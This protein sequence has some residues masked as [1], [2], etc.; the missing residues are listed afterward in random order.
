MTNQIINVSNATELKTAL[1]AATG[2]E[3]VILAAGDYGKLSISGTQF[4]SNVTLKSADA[5]GMASFSEAYLKNSS[6]ITFD[7]I[8]FD[9]SYS[10]GEA[11]YASKF[12]V[13][14]STNISFNDSLF[15][16]DAANGTGT[17]ADGLGTGK[18][19]VVKGSTN[20]DVV[21][22]EFHS[23]W[24]GLS[25]NTS[26]NI[27][28][29]GNNIHN[30]RSDGMKLG[31][32]QTVLVEKNYIHDFNGD[33]T[34][35][36]HRDM[37]QIQRS[38]GT[39]V[40]D[41]TIRDNVFDMGSGD[42]TQTIWAGRDKGNANDPT[43]WHQNVLIENNV[44]YNAHTHGISL[45]LTDGLTIRDNSLIAVDR[46][47]T[48]GISIPKILVSSE[49]KS[50]V[51]ENNITPAIGGEQGQAD[52]S[53]QNNAFIQNT[54][55]NAPGYY[56]NQFIYHATALA[57]GHNQF[58]IAVGSM[59]DQLT[60]GSSLSNQPSFSY[61]DW[62]GTASTVVSNP[63]SSGGVGNGGVV[64]T[65][66]SNTDTGTEGSVTE[67]DSASGPS[68]AE[69]PEMP[70][71]GG[72]T[73]GDTNVPE[74]NENEAGDAEAPEIDAT[75]TD[76]T[77]TGEAETG[78]YEVADSVVSDTNNESQTGMTF[79]DF[80]LDIAVLATNGQ[81]EFRGDATVV[82]TASGTAIQFDGHGDV[83]SMGRLKQFE[84]S[85]QIA[86]N[87]EFTRDEA[88]GSTQRLVWNH[89]KVGLT[90]TDDGLI[91][92]VRNNDDPFHKGFRV[93]NL[94]LNDTDTHTVSLMVDQASD[95]LQVL[96]DD[97]L[98]LD[99]T[100]TDFDFVG[101]DN[102]EWGWNL[103]TGWGD[104]IDGE[105]SGF[106]IEDDVQFIDPPMVPDDMFA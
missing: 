94:G 10:S 98:V 53:V 86:F 95:R 81:A 7:T 29:S 99:E 48:G 15:D 8:K 100:D 51:V 25:I 38:S 77:E 91:A 83:V 102:N 68:E 101:G 88:D 39:G 69:V 87:V 47:Q 12:S 4:A 31:S 63:G 79:D 5:N 49:S 80:V 62:V 90:L 37:I 13:E 56:D 22:S 14:N 76:E 72:A 96:V 105:V 3:T 104:Y 45:N 11:Y 84:N 19:L 36:D 34:L 20:V 61:D 43:N 106:A 26:S 58:E 73:V 42:W 6:N 50:V 60:A 2:G 70:E 18:G 21:N 55:A 75:G 28:I 54:D 103:G 16:G 17:A 52:W 9:Y 64:G 27:H 66:S 44:I 46:A 93:D 33:D 23:F 32:S 78:D 82:D 57:N 30:I 85:E 92:H 74:T 35:S 1:A 67:L 89:R 65:D 59:V 41:L 97:K 71:N 40:S 24:T